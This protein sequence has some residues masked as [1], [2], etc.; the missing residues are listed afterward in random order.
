LKGTVGEAGEQP[1]LTGKGKVAHSAKAWWTEQH[2]L[3]ERQGEG[4][5]QTDSTGYL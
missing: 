3:F 4:R 2:F 5:W 1:G